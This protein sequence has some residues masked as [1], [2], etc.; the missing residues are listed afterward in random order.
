MVRYF[1]IKIKTLKPY[2]F[3]KLNYITKHCQCDVCY[4]ADFLLNYSSDFKDIC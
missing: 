4:S 1:L 3:S 2:S